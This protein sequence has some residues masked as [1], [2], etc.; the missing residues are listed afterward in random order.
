MA[1]VHDITDKTP[2]ALLIEL[3][4]FMLEKAK[5]GEIRSIFCV[6][7]W[8]NGCVDCGWSLDP[9]TNPTKFV[10]GIT[11]ASQDFTLNRLNV[12]AD[13]AFHRIIERGD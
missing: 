9:R 2:N 7:A 13:S 12:D 1:E 5:A 8:D 6:T 4:D 10:G 11:L 3:L